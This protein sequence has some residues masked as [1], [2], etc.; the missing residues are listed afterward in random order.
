M[1]RWRRRLALAWPIALS[2]LI[3]WC[4]ADRPLLKREGLEPMALM[5]GI[6]GL[7]A[8]FLWKG[9]GYF[10]M[11]A[12][13]F[14]AAGAYV[15][16]GWAYSIEWSVEE[17]IEAWRARPRGNARKVVELGPAA[18]FYQGRPIPAWIRTSDGAAW[19]F[20]SVAADRKGG[21]RAAADPGEECFQRGR[22]VYRLRKSAAREGEPEPGA[23]EGGQAAQ[24]EGGGRRRRNTALCASR[25]RRLLETRRRHGR[26]AGGERRC[27]RSAAGRN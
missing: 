3:G 20:H 9:G 1:R 7:G 4:G 23:E 13:L 22:L 2:V 14:F 26:E 17:A 5:A 18:G 8:F 25:A 11:G 12:V 16:R 15:M 27:S 19:D 21:V 24:P 6:A 10:T